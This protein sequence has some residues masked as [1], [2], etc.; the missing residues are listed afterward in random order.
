MKNLLIWTAIDTVVS[1]GVACDSSDP[2]ELTEAT[3]RKAL[4]SHYSKAPACLVTHAE[5]PFTTNK[6]LG[7]H[8]TAAAASIAT[9][10]W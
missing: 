2:N 4:E 1:V 6:S 3:I 7:P 9:G 8:V 10:A 5:F